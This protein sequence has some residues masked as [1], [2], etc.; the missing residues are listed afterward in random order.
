MRAQ[1]HSS[2][3]EHQLEQLVVLPAVQYANDSLREPA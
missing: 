3:L 2:R 1:Q